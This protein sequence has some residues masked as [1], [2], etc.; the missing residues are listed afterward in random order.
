MYI[1]YFL[2]GVLNVVP[3]EKKDFTYLLILLTWLI[4]KMYSALSQHSC[5]QITV[6]NNQQK[7]NYHYLITEFIQKDQK[8]AN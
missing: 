3:L 5:N 8:Q 4:H 2:M 7:L 1:M 6:I